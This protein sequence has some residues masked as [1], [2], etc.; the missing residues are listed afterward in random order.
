VQETLENRGP[1]QVR[2]WIRQ[3]NRTLGELGREESLSLADEI[4]KA[5]AAHV[6]AIEIDEYPEGSNTG[7][8]IIELPD[9]AAARERVLA[10]AGVIARE[11]GFDAESDIGQRYVFSMLD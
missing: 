3:E 11:Q 8:L 1:Q 6:Y 2:D 5:G 10:W 9:D 7:K 4:Y